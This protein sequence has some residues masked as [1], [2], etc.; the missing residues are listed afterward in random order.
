MFTKLYTIFILLLTIFFTKQVL[1]LADFGFF[2]SSEGTKWG[3]ATRKH[4]RS[5]QP[6][7]SKTNILSWERHNNKS[8]KTISKDSLP[9]TY[10]LY[11][12]KL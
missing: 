11:G 8:V 1:L 4:F 3:Q 5:I 7:T 12:V 9:S 2:F 6:Y 10:N